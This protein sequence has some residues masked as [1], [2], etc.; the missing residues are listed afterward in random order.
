[1]PCNKKE[2]F[3]KIFI[4]ALA[5]LGM[6]AIPTGEAQARRVKVVKPAVVVVATPATVIRVGR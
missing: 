4:L 1:M 6:F 5:V 2:R 3:V